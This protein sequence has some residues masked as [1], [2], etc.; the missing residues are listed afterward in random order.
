MFEKEKR[1][2]IRIASFLNE[3]FTI[4]NI[5]VL[6]LPYGTLDKNLPVDAE[7]TDLIPD[8]RRSHMPWSN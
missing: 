5:F 8:A 6:D 1:R 7:D 2:G 3:T 4:K